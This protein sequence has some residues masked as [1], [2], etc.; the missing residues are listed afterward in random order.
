MD[1]WVLADI[2]VCESVNYVSFSCAWSVSKVFFF[3]PEKQFYKSFRKLATLQL[4]GPK[5]WISGEQT[6]MTS[7]ISLEES[8]EIWL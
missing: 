2:A 3:I 8:Y 1:F 6:L 7:E 4:E 5:P